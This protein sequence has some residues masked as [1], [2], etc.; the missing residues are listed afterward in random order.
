MKQRIKRKGQS[1]RNT[2]ESRQQKRNTNKEKDRHRDRRLIATTWLL[3]FFVKYVY[4]A[5][6]SLHIDN[7]TWKLYKRVIIM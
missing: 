6:Y 2:D 4:W 7:G 5:S 3:F 1:N